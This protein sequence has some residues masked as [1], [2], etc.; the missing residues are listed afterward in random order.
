MVFHAGNR[1]MTMPLTNRAVAVR[2]PDGPVLA[3]S[4]EGDPRRHLAEWMTKPDN[5]WFARLA[6]NRLWKHYLGR[7]LVEPED[8]LR[9]T[10]P[11]TNEPLLNYLAQTLV[12]EK[13]DLKAVTR[14]I[15]SS[16]T[17]QLASVPNQTNRDD[18]QHYSH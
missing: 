15:L 12:K 11:A 7:G 3:A 2:P 5:P 16:R 8:D 14:L 4:V 1:P 18:E 17:Y 9:S 6:V 13:Y 10:N